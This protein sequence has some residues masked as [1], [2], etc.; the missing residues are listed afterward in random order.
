[1]Q[2]HQRLHAHAFLMNTY[3]GTLTYTN[4]PC[5]YDFQAFGQPLFLAIGFTSC[6][7][8]H[9]W[10][11][12]DCIR[13]FVQRGYR[14]F[15]AKWLAP[16]VDPSRTSYSCTRT[17]ILFM[18]ALVGSSNGGGHTTYKHAQHKLYTAFILAHKSVA[19][20]FDPLRL[21]SYLRR[22]S[23][24]TLRWTRILVLLRQTRGATTSSRSRMLSQSRTPAWA[25]M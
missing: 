7:K 19:R 12:K 16:F 25:L 21:C 17:N 10:K 8:N 3:I 2:A 6:W 22:Q 4:Q 1:M 18:P 14:T 15:V 5:Q 11:N 13:I 9:G 23:R 20:Q 24:W